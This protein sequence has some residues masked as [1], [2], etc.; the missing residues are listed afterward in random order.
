MLLKYVCIVAL[1]TVGTLQSSTA[2]A[3]MPFSGPGLEVG[4]ATGEEV[5]QSDG[6]NMAYYEYSDAQN[7]FVLV[8]RWYEPGAD[9]LP[10]GP[11]EFDATDI[12]FPAGTL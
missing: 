3:C 5:L 11:D 8:S 6:A 9:L 4:S 2:V 7:G 1:A 12:F 10:L